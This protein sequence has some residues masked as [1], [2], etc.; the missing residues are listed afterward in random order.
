MFYKSIGEP[1]HDVRIP[2]DY[3][4]HG[5]EHRVL[6]PVEGGSWPLLVL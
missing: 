2:R 3:F 5:F 6:I 4:K 1:K